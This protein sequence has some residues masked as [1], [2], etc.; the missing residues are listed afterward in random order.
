MSSCWAPDGRLM[1]SPDWQDVERV[2]NYEF[3][4]KVEDYVHRIGRTGRAGAKGLAVT[5]MAAAD[6]KHAGAL[7]KILKESVRGLRLD[8][9]L[10][11]LI[12]S[13]TS[14]RF[15]RNRCADCAAD[16]GPSH[17]PSHVPSR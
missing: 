5:F 7:V 9:A 6:A 8:C 2:I 15:S 1:S 10:I 14:S 17:C 16:R 12:G 3:P 13:S 4:N 11:A